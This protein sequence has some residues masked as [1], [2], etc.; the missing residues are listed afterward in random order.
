VRKMCV[1]TLAQS[2][3]SAELERAGFF[4]RA[5]RSVMLVQKIREVPPVEDFFMTG[6]SLSS[7]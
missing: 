2:R 5:V 3:F 6:F 4:P 1:S 7:W